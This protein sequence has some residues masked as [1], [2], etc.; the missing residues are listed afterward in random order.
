MRF[1]H[2]NGPRGLILSVVFV[3]LSTLGLTACPVPTGPPSINP[4]CSAEGNL[5]VCVYKDENFEGPEKEF[6]WSDADYTND[7]LK[8]VW[9]GEL[10]GA[11]DAGSSFRNGTE[12]WVVFFYDAS[13]RGRRAVCLAPGQNLVKAPGNWLEA[14]PGDNVSSHL[15]VEYADFKNLANP[16]DVYVDTHGITHWLYYAPTG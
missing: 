1:V 15:V 6:K 11:N 14:G 2:G 13:W 9:S 4:Y 3:A 8:D 5:T 7:T 12:K 10:A 16:C